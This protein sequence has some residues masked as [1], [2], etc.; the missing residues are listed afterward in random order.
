VSQWQETLSRLKDCY[1]G[2]IYNKSRA[3][4]LEQL[5]RQL[6]EELSEAIREARGMLQRRDAITHTVRD[7]D[8]NLGSRRSAGEPP[9]SS[10]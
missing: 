8:D 4:E 5:N 6:Q 1:V 9:R 2:L 10:E 7:L 3:E